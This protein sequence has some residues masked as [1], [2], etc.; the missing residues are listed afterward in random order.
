M[1]IAMFVS[2]QGNGGEEDATRRLGA[3]P[4]PK[5]M[6]KRSANNLSGYFSRRPSLQSRAREQ[7]IWIQKKSEKVRGT[8]V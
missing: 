6:K 2:L 8:S 7:S 3:N 5:R 4:W 1:S